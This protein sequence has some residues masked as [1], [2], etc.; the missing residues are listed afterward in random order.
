VDKFNYFKSLLKDAA[1]DAIVGLTLT[2]AHYHEAVEILRKRFGNRQLIIAR[3]MEILLGIEPVTADNYLR[4][5]WYLFDTTESHIRS[6]KSL[7]V[8]PEMYGSMLA[9]V[10]LTKL[11]PNLRLIVSRDMSYYDE[12]AIGKLL[13]MFEEIVARERE[14]NSSTLPAERRSKQRERNVAL[15]SGAPKSRNVSGI[16]C[17]YW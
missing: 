12:M 16:S 11:P 6:L 17:C 14:S 2:A 3:H 13:K 7:G 15:V 1:H 5:L 10:L 8:Q 9:S 4:Y